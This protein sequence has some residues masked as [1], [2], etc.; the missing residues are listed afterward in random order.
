MNIASNSKRVNIR[1][2]LSFFSCCLLSAVWSTLWSLVGPSWVPRGSLV[3]PLVE[4]LVGE[5]VG[6]LVGDDV[7]ELVWNVYTSLFQNVLGTIS[8]TTSFSSTSVLSHLSFVLQIMS[9]EWIEPHTVSSFLFPFTHRSKH[10]ALLLSS[11]LI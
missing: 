6:A 11:N 8:V 2:F 9:L 10:L 1:V 3:G 4:E 5:D 7:R